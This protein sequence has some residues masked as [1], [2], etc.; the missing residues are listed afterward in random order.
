VDS[1]LEGYAKETDSRARARIYARHLAK[2]A[3]QPGGGMALLQRIAGSAKIQAS[4]SLG[5]LSGS[6]IAQA[7]LG[8][9]MV[10]LPWLKDLATDFSNA[11]AKLNQTIYTRV[12][13]VPTV[14]TYDPATGFVDAAATDVDVPVVIDDHFFVQIGY[15]ANELAST[16]RDLFAEQVEGCSYAMVKYMVDKVFALITV[17]NFSLSPQ[18]TVQA[19]SGFGRPT[20]KSMG[21]ALT[22]HGNAKAGRIL[23]LNP[24]FYDSLGEDPALLGLAAF[25]APELI[26][27]NRLGRVSGFETFEAANL[28]TT[29]NLVG[30]GATNGALV[31]ATRMPNDYTTAQIGANYGSVSQI[32]EPV[33]GLTMMLTQYVSHDAGVSRYRLSCMGGAA[34]GDKNRGQLLVS[35]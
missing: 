30:F 7:S 1:A 34:L 16:N 4:N 19:L 5:T 13:G 21:K 31:L 25:Q 29:A 17:S 20:I 15:N 12:R 10:D 18:K 32:E 9:L 23:L 11:A 28:P 2:I 14:G 35:A 24:D 27:E 22:T 26:R 8:L 6:L 3:R 33:T